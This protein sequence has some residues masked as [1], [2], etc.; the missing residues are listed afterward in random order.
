MLH[1]RQLLR[2]AA[3]RREQP[4]LRLTFAQFLLLFLALARQFA[5]TIRDKGQPEPIRRPGRTTGAGFARRVT[6]GR[7]ARCRY[8]P[9]GSMILIR[10]LVDGL[11]DASHRLP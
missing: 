3:A 10:V 11:N 8:D 1:K 4:D 9:D 6:P 5:F 7:A 2:F